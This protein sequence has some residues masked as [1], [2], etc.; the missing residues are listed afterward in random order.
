MKPV[1]NAHANGY[2]IGEV[3]T[4]ELKGENIEPRSV[5]RLQSESTPISPN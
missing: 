4:G 5:G 1:E 3:L 2:P